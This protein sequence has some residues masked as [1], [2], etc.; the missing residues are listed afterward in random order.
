MKLNKIVLLAS[1]TALSSLS[2]LSLAQ[3]NAIERSLSQAEAAIDDATLTTRVKAR[4]MD[5]ERLNNTDID[6]DSNNGVV[7][8]KGSANTDEARDRAEELARQ[9]EGV[10]EVRNQIATPST[11]NT[12]GERSQ[13][14]ADD[15]ERVISDSWITTKVRGSL[16]TDSAVEGHNVGIKTVEGVVHLSGHVKSEAARERAIQVAREIKGVK[17]V[18]ADELTVKG[19]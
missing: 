4:L 11:R 15:A 10:K 3:E 2:P 5:D 19:K 13:E 18:K 6:V 1:L 14:A 7:T 9:V 17:E 16:L 12:I 8:L